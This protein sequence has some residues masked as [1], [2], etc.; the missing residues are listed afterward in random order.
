MTNKFEWDDADAVSD[1][2]WWQVHGTTIQLYLHPDRHRLCKYMYRWLRTY[3]RLNLYNTD[4]SEPS[5]SCATLQSRYTIICY[6]TNVL[7]DKPCG[8]NGSNSWM[9]FF[10]ISDTP[11][12]R[13][14]SESYS[15]KLW[16]I[17]HCTLTSPPEIP[18]D[19]L[20]TKIYKRH[21]DISTTNTNW[22]GTASE[23]KTCNRV[24]QYYSKS[25]LYHNKVDDNINECKHLG[26][27]GYYKRL[28]NLVLQSWSLWNEDSHT[29]NS[30][31]QSR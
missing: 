10:L 21:I 11:L 22:L 31:N 23:W 28:F 1:L 17:A 8:M 7:N 26:Q 6:V 25:S 9:L 14:S 5:S 3:E 4:S 30:S 2:I 19:I 20:F 12:P 13:S 27:D 16:H 15:T 24:V 29:L 18:I